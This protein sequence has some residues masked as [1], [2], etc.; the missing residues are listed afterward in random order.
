MLISISQQIRNINPLL[1]TVHTLLF[2]SVLA[3]MLE[4]GSN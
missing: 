2:Q 1:M 4:L 3:R